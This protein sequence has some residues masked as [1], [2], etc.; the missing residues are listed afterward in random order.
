MSTDEPATSCC[1]CLGHLASVYS[2]WGILFIQ[3]IFLLAQVGPGGT[4]V[5]KAAGSNPTWQDPTQPPRATLMLD[6][7]PDE[8]ERVVIVIWNKM[9]KSTYRTFFAKSPHEETNWTTSWAPLP[10]IKAT[11]YFCKHP[12]LRSALHCLVSFG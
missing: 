9:T 5:E 3:G 7:S 10:L 4:G 6:Q 1:V 8:N 2:R 11:I 12:L